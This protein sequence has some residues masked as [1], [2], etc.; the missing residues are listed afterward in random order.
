MTIS[1]N[2]YEAHQDNIISALTNLVAQGQR[3]IAA[4]VV[5]GLDA[6][7]DNTYVRDWAKKNANITKYDFDLA[8][9]KHR[10]A[11][12]AGTPI[13]GVRELVSN[14]ISENNIEVRLDGAVIWPGKRNTRFDKL[15]R[16]IRLHRDD[17]GLGG[18]KN[19]SIA[20]AFGEWIDR[21][22]E[23]R[24]KILIS[25]VTAPLSVA[26]QAAAEQI[27]MALAGPV[28]NDA[29]PAFVGGVLKA[30]MWQVKRKM[31]G[32]PVYRHLM[33]VL[34]GLTEK[35]KSTFVELMTSP[36]AEVRRP[37]TFK[38]LEDEK[39]I[40]MWSS[41]IGVLDEMDH[42]DKSNV[43][44]IKN[45]ITAASVSRRPMYSNH[46]VSVDQ[47]L[48]LIGTS[49]KELGQSIKDPTSARRFI[50]LDWQNEPDYDFIN[51]I[52]WLTMWRSVDANAPHPMEQFRAELAAR[53]GLVRER[54]RVEA[55]LESNLRLYIAD[56]GRKSKEELFSIFA[57]YEDNY[58]RSSFK[59]SLHEWQK[60]MTRLRKQIG[61]AKFPFEWKR[62]KSGMVYEFRED[63]HVAMEK[64]ANGI[65]DD[66][67]TMPA[68]FN[69]PAAPDG[70]PIETL[71]Q[72][73]ARW[74]K[75]IVHTS[76]HEYDVL[77]GDYVIKEPRNST[78]H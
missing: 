15:E 58:N 68:P 20:D 14:F 17:I 16:D 4:D 21:A 9:R 51:A 36:L 30:L 74:R 27:W 54:S 41:F 55:W 47:N 8:M 56:G 45:V 26:E 39:N 33:P 19:E 7:Q 29:N 63:V 73:N 69:A 49:N 53:Q 76:V 61:E 32:F 22:K 2:E 77:N 25:E 52:D 34:L 50:G 6:D 67:N 23:D 46:M 18:V 31:M 37:L 71:E 72:A 78:H 60:E 3:I 57:D 75:G 13:S 12:K 1:R 40:E 38:Q 65:I 43:D 70:A 66:D 44:T 62:V 24:L 5:A 28:F 59:T 48:T 10:I 11:E 35:G 64:A 42:A